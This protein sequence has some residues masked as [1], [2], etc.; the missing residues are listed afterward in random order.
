MWVISHRFLDLQARTRYGRRSPR[1]TMLALVWLPLATASLMGR[2]HALSFS[3]APYPRASLVKAAAVASTEAALVQSVDEDALVLAGTDAAHGRPRRGQDGRLLPMLTLP[4]DTLQTTWSMVA[5][6]ASSTLLTVAAIVRAFVA[7]QS[8][9]TPLLGVCLGA[10]RRRPAP[11]EQPTERVPPCASDVVGRP[12]PRPS[13]RNGVLRTLLS[14]AHSFTGGRRTLQRCLPLG[15]GQLRP[16]GDARRGLRVRGVPR[17]P[18][19]AMDHLASIRVE[20]CPQDRRCHPPTHPD[21]A[22]VAATSGCRL[23][24]CHVV[25]SGH[26]AGVPSV[27]AHDAQ[28]ARPMAALAPARRHRAA[29][30]RALCPP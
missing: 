16:F 1:Q 17:P 11:R 6:T 23:H 15:N 24:R 22:R 26:G 8:F 28:H 13:K 5:V 9:L 14:C 30:P 12:F 2:S 4:G 19:C 20:Q 3:P 18:S 25:Q 27:V 10:V 7:S 21:G 29:F